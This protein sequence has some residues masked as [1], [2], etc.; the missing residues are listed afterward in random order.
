MTKAWTKDFGF[1]WS[2]DR[3]GPN[4]QFMPGSAFEPQDEARD[5]HQRPLD[6]S[7]QPFR[8][9]SAKHLM[10][11]RLPALSLVFHRDEVTEA[12]ALTTHLSSPTRRS[13]LRISHFVLSRGRHTQ[14][15]A[16]V[17]RVQAER[18]DVRQCGV[19]RVWR[20]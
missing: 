6:F 12:I 16:R 3:T 2:L 11:V 18:D 9:C 14:L 4:A 8:G 10:P 17:W 15:H 5:S 19:E 7:N 20:L 1:E 13:I